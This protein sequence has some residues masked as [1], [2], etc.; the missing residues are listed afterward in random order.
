MNLFKRIFNIDKCSSLDTPSAY[1]ND[2][3]STTQVPKH[4][5]K[6]SKLIIQLKNCRIVRNGALV[7]DDLFIRNGLIIDPEKLFFDERTT[8][9][10]QIDCDGL[11]VAP[12]FIDVQLNGAFGRDFTHNTA[13]R[14]AGDVH[15][16]SR[17]IL[18]YGVTSFLPTLVSSPPAQYAQLIRQIKRHTSLD[19][20]AAA[21]DDSRSRA[22][23]LGVHLEGPFI[24]PSKAGAHELLNL[25]TFE[26]G[27]D[28]LERVYGSSIDELKEHV[29][30]ITLA[31]ELDPSGS[32]IDCL[33]QHG[34]VVS[35]G[36]S[37]ADLA[38]GVHAFS[39]GARFITHLFN[40]MLPFHHRDPHL[41]GLLSDR[42]LL[43]LDDPIY[44]GV[45]ADDIHTHPAAIN[46]SYKAHPNGLVLVTDAMAA[47]GLDDVEDQSSSSPSSS[48]SSSVDQRHQ[49]G[50]RSVDIVRDPVTK[51]ICTAFVHGTSTLSG[52]VASMDECVR[53][54]KR[55]TGCSL[56]DALMCACEHPARML[57]V[58]PHKGCLEYG[59]DADFVVIDDQVNVKATFIGGDLAW[60]VADW[61]PLF[62]YKFIP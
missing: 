22:N 12:G 55:A 11:I 10:M 18:Q 44:Y 32:V 61:S 17:K 3:S 40:A 7:H 46:I 37:M 57:G 45:I 34:I 53:N 36:H 2:S 29:S 56:V 31:P 20:T 19:S 30:L 48:S 51:R 16:V 13:E 9:D 38:V 52:S 8:A 26:F 62:K 27:L 47:M 14:I 50:N 4:T 21:N 43:R 39:H 42:S 15:Y 59:A 58:Y 25:A 24:S 23:V 41:I 35:I 33:S 28:S 54:L 5:D 1:F 60:S 6:A 49:L